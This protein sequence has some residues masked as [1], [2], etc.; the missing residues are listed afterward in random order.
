MLVANSCYI[1]CYKCVCFVYTVVVTIRF[2]QGAYN[3]TDGKANI[4]LLLSQ[5][6]RT[7]P[8]TVHGSFVSDAGANEDSP[9]GKCLLLMLSIKFRAV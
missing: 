3:A 2:S 1:K 7:H 6:L 9:K 8:L 5:P 4:V